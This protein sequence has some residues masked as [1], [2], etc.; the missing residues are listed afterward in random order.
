MSKR[1]CSR[2]YSIRMS[3]FAS[4]GGALLLAI[5]SSALAGGF[6]LSVETPSSSSDPQMKDVVL[7]A[8]TY[9]CH[10]PADAKLS[11]TAEGLVNGARKSVALE[12]RSIGSGVYAIKQQWPSE[13]TWVLSIS[14]AY[15]GMTS[16]V[17]VELGPNGKVLPGTRLD[18]GAMKGVHARGAR[19]QWIAEDIDSALRASA[20][21]TSETSG[22]ADQTTPGP[23]TWILAGLGASVV[24]IGF[25]TRAR[26]RNKS[27]EIAG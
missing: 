13:G 15:N 4:L 14:G 1:S 25:V 23:I 11:A 21:L 17:L 6:Q 3:T 24:S 16:S 27:G 20:G 5:S 26:R 12:L 2:R 9:G 10:Q 7:V 19:R 22:D 8:R 18:E